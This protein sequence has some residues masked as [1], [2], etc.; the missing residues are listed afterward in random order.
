[1]SLRKILRLEDELE[2]FDLRT[3]EIDW[4]MQEQAL[5]HWRHERELDILSLW[6]EK[7]GN[8]NSPW[9]HRK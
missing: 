5:D 3:Q 4:E 2:A 7:E 9:F 8:P 1:M 6:F